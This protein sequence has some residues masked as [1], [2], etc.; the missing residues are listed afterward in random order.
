MTDDERAAERG[1]ALKCARVLLGCQQSELATVL[2][3]DQSTVSR[4]E[5][6]DRRYL[7]HQDRALAVLTAYFMS[8]N[9]ERAL[10]VLGVFEGV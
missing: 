3:V 6:G 10:N 1:R 4:M 5:S 7:Q 2:K 8:A 9:D